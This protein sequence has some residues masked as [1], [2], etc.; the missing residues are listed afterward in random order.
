M[1]GAG[2]E[3]AAQARAG[4]ILGLQ[5]ENKIPLSLHGYVAVALEQGLIDVIPVS[6]GAMFDP[7]G[8]IARVDAARFLLRLL[9][10]K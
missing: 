7:K 1:R 10:L 4:E 6:G 3:A 5:D 2:L 9:E 8:D